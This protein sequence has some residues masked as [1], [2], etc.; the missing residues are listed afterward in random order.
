MCLPP[1][2]GDDVRP[3]SVPN[4]G[5]AVP[6]DID[7]GADEPQSLDSRVTPKKR[8]RLVRNVSREPVKVSKIKQNSDLETKGCG[9]FGGS[10]TRVHLR[11]EAHAVPIR[12]S[13]HV[14]NMVSGDVPSG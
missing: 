4:D 8:D 1:P 5:P 11:V 6:T 9:K 10:D 13:F 2:D 7:G 14:E 12:P 3:P